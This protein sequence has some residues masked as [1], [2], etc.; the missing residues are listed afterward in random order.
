ME[1]PT[2][3]VI[4]KTE[5]EVKAPVEIDYS[6]A[7]DGTGVIHGDRWL[8][9]F[10]Q[11]LR[12]RFATYKWYKNEIVQREG[13]LLEFTD[14]NRYGLIREEGGVRYRDWAPAA[15][16]VSLT[17]D[18]NEWNF[19]SHFC[20]RNEY[21]VWEIFIPDIDGR[22]VIQHNSKIKTVI[23]TEND[24]LVR[25]SPWIHYA[26]AERG[27]PTYDGRFWNPPE[28]E[29][30]V[31]KYQSPTKPERL[32]I[33]EVHIGMAS[34][35]QK[36]GTY[37]EFIN[38]LPYI[39]STGYNCI[40]MMAVMEHSYYASFGY[41]VTN[42]FAASS[43]FGT[44]EELKQLIDH[45]H[46]LG[47]TV[48]LDL[49]HSHASKNTSDG[50]NSF[51]GSD[52]CHF[53]G[54]TRGTH[55]LWDSRIFD[56]KAWEVIRF[57]L[58]NLRYWIEEY[59]LD[60]F[61]FD[62][63]TAMLLQ[64]RAIGELPTDYNG[65]FGPAVDGD[66]LRYLTLANDMLHEL[67]P[68]IITIAEDAMGFACLCRPTAEGGVGFDF[69][70]GMGLPDMWKKLMVVQDEA[71]NMGS[72]CFELKNRR[73]HEKTIAYVESHDQ[74]LVGDKTIAF[75]LMDKEMY[76]NM[77][78]LSPPNLI[79]DR[80]IQ[81][82]KMIRLLTCAMGGEGYLTFMGNEFGH[83]EWIDFP[84][85]GNGQ[86]FHYSCRRWYLQKDPLLRYQHLY[87]F[88]KDMLQ[89]E[90]KY[91]WLNYKDD[92]VGMKHEAMKIISYERAKLVFLFNFH[93]TESYTDLR[94]PVRLAGKYIPVLDSDIVEFGGH[95]R[96]QPV[97]FFSQDF[98]YEG[99]MF[100]IQVYL[101][102]RSALVLR[103]ED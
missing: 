9:P 24:K 25:I 57:L 79:V 88:E 3:K 75:W 98:P 54:G 59:H 15:L 32:R 66:A 99:A 94:V 26:T 18:F 36:I 5:P 102:S 56:Y 68:N 30:H 95:N 47:L 73:Y 84:R 91:S 39:A 86:S 8:E 52:S 53:L 14:Y 34:P 37:L 78:I 82:H 97:E 40:Q 17:G 23:H 1:T 29:K 101:P 72:I 13:S 44:P 65:Y 83:P 22:E 10:A 28:S 11:T 103:R 19:S 50:L 27:N 80:G 77:S 4:E 93:A 70:L 16:G 69:R 85:E 71:W 6:N 67:Y 35:D 48:L 43:R 7:T 76:T 89:L 20:T 12:D 74:A 90:K 61:R 41:Q 100:S 87:N 81:L 96:T 62:G 21:G 64:S 63:V 51:D 58:A 31:W 46:S 38:L 49:V 55:Q 60:G 45:A 33:Y 92:F 2:K 42:F